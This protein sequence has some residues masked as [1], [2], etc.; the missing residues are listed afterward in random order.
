MQKQR[1]K[2]FLSTTHFCS[3]GLFL[4]SV[5]PSLL[6]PH[7][8]TDGPKLPSIIQCTAMPVHP[9]LHPWCYTTHTHTHTQR[10]CQFPRQDPCLSSPDWISLVQHGAVTLGLRALHRPAGSHVGLKKLGLQWKKALGLDRVIF[11]W[12]L[13]LLLHKLEWPHVFVFIHLS[14]VV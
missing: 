1:N 12:W 11:W 7:H 10:Q 6:L 3:F 5:P 4:L 2:E 13:L 9:R 14:P 8:H